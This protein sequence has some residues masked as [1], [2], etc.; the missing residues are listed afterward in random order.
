MFCSHIFQQQYHIGYHQER[1]EGTVRTQIGALTPGWMLAQKNA[2]LLNTT[3]LAVTVIVVQR[4]QLHHPSIGSISIR[5]W[6]QF[7]QN[8]TAEEYV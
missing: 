4:N 3:A 5:A 7:V 2:L 6:P 1:A 8:R